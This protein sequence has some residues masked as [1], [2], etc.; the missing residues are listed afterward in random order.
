M[1]IISIIALKHLQNGVVERLQTRTK[2]ERVHNGGAR[3]WCGRSG[4]S[5]RE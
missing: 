4:G 3:S 2:M 5:V 1:P